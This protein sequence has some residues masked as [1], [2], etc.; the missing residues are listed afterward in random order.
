MS[1]GAEPGTGIGDGLLRLSVGL[2]AEEELIAGLD[3]GF[4]RADGGHTGRRFST[5]FPRRPGAGLRRSTLTGPARVLA[6]IDRLAPP[7]LS[8]LSTEPPQAHLQA[9][10]YHWP[11]VP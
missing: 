10:T 9:R 3:R 6:A 4:S 5:Y 1:I 2:E 11:E 7:S 8:Y